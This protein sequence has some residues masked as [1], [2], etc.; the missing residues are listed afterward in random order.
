MDQFPISFGDLKNAVPLTAWY[1]MGLILLLIIAQVS[2]RLGGWLL[3]VIVMGLLYNA[4]NNPQGS[5]I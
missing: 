1:A 2:P 3:I 4:H 5:L